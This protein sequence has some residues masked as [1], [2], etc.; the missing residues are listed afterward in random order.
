MNV[1]SLLNLYVEYLLSENKIVW[2]FALHTALKKCKRVLIEQSLLNKGFAGT[3]K[4]LENGSW[5]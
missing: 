4:V 2:K 1:I 3:L 5:C